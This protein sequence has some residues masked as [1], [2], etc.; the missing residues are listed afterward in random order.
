MKQTTAVSI[1]TTLLKIIGALLVGFYLWI[2]YSIHR[3]TVDKGMQRSLI[4]SFK[5]AFTM[6]V[7]YGSL[8]LHELTYG[9]QNTAPKA[10]NS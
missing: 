9:P 10:Y 5:E 8:Y 1:L 7:I 4:D 6:L 3:S 2:V